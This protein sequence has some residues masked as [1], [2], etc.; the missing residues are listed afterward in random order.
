MALWWF[1]R[2]MLNKDVNVSSLCFFKPGSKYLDS[3][4][5]SIYSKSN[6]TPFLCME[7]LINEISNSA[8]WA[9]STESLQ[10]SIN[11]SSSS[12][13]DGQPATVA[14]SIVVNSVILY[15]IWKPGSVNSEK[16]SMTLPSCI[17]TAPI[18]IILSS[19]AENPVV[20]TSKTTK[21]FLLSPL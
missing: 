3:S 20:S 18:S 6:L 12:S 17:F 9:T 13:K 16:L 5:V 14:S 1:S 19:M 11:F 21:V 7:L 15:G 4:S 2:V 8:L 10:K